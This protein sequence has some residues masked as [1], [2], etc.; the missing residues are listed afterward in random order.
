MKTKA[1]LLIIFQFLFSTAFGQKEPTINITYSKL[2]ATYDF[3]QKLS[4]NYPDN[5]C[6]Q[7]FQ[8]SKFRTPAPQDFVRKQARG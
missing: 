8:S 6:K 2:L 1:T 3:I 4:D 5:E 7:L